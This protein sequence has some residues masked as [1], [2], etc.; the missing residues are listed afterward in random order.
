MNLIKYYSTNGK[1]PLVSFKGAIF[2][3]LAPDKGLFMPGRIPKISLKEITAMKEMPYWEIAFTVARKFLQGEIPDNELQRI[4]KEA[5]NFRVPLERVAKRN[6]LLLLDQ[7]ATASFKD[8]AACLMSRLVQFFLL[9]EEKQMTIITATSGDTGS[10]V[11]NAF[12]GLKNI[13]M[14]VLFPE[15]EVSETQ[16]KQMTTLGGNII[17]IAVDGKFDDCQAIV[18]KAFADNE[19]Q[20]FNLSSANSIN[21]GR[22]LPQA[23]YYFYAYAKLFEKIGEKIVFSVPSGNFGN[24]CAGI[25]AKRMGLPVEK[26]VIAVNEN[27]EFPRFLETGKYKKIVPSRECLSNAMNV[28]HPSNLARVVDLYGGQMDETGKVNKLPDLKKMRK[29]IFSLSVSD[30]QTKLAIKEAFS[31][32][33]I[34]LEP[35]GAVGWFALQEFLK[36]EKKKFCVSIETAHPA[37]FPE[38]IKETIGI[39]P[40]RPKSFAGLET[41]Q[42]KFEK[43]PN[44]YTKFK[45][46][47]IN[48]F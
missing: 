27:N 42:E 29:D 36:N 44:D 21:F 8:F 45:E 6:Y 38:I 37:K 19:L 25:I 10:A 46:F 34:V 2:Q 16:R 33:K 5:Y 47:L 41:K 11:A 15:R 18:K 32:Y 3:G 26:F 35:H 17:A 12:F 22:L 20:K 14:V 9:Q 7:G 13:K 39:D 30:A 28:G 1:A 40:E 4:C 43:M 24:V 48:N 31:K 23:I